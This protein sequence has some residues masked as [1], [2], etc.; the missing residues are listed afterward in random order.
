MNA[1][2]RCSERL[3]RLGR[4]LL[5]AALSALLPLAAE[6]HK[7]SDS[8]LTLGRET[9]GT[10]AL[11]WDIALRDLELPLGL[12]A[13]GDGLLRWGE[14]R[15]RLPEIEAHAVRHL[16]LN[17]GACR[18]ELR[19]QG[20]EQRLD[21]N[22]LALAGHYRC[23]EGELHTIDYRLL[24]AID[25]TH[26]GLLRW[27][28]AAGAPVS[29]SLDPKGG[30]LRL[31]RSGT[32]AA[33]GFFRDGVR[34]ILIGYDHLLFL[35]CLLLPAVM[36]RGPAGWQPVECLRTALWPVLKTVSLFTVAHS[37]TLALATLGVVRL[38][39]AFVEAA[40]AA[41]IVLVALHNL[42]PLWRGG[43]GWL[44][45]GFGLVHG[46]GFAGVLAEL[47]LP[48]AGFAL[49]LLQFN[50]GVEAGQ[51][52]VVGAA[53]SLFYLLRRQRAPLA[54]LMPAASLVAMAVAG[55]WFCERVFD[56]RLIS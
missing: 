6:A 17:A 9:G 34:H 7:A 38:P 20:L 35:L 32:P 54:R 4:G 48:S 14:V 56:L 28:P 3:R 26:R 16:Q 52:A 44:A 47:E 10:A 51:L 39:G 24:G 53:G 49:A 11:R 33:Q 19:S 36:R 21:G 45:F 23:P 40:I 37:I 1:S 18:V 43:E 25:P 15:R 8:Y 22:Y 55:T 13:D 50:L 46:F 30:P 31:V 5:L 2:P 12:D 41:S 42:R 27:T 29:L